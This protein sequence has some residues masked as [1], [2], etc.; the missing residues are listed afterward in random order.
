MKILYLMTEPLGIGG[1]Q[2]DMLALSK[3]FTEKGHEY[4]LAT[5]DGEIR[6]EFEANGG[7][8]HIIDFQYSGLAGLLS[9]ANKLRLLIRKL[10]VDV[11]APQSVRTSIVAWIAVRLM[12]FSYRI[13]GGNGKLPLVTTIHNIHNPVHFSYGG[14]ILRLCADYV[15]FESNYER[16]RL[17]SSGLTA[18]RSSV[19]HSGIDL[20]KLEP[21]AASTHLLEQWGINSEKDI[22]LGIVAR[23]SEEKGH[24]YLFEA[25]HIARQSRPELKLLVIGDGPL[26]DELE[27][28]VD[29]L[30][31][32]DCITFTGT[33][34][35]IPEYLSIIDVF[36]LSST[37]ESFPLAA[38]EAMAS[39]KAVVAPRI[40]GCGE[41]V[42]EGSTGLL[43]EAANVDDLAEKIVAI[44]APGMSVKFGAAGRARAEE[45]FSLKSWINGDEAIY[46]QSQKG[47]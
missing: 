46:I 14:W 39:G 44:T 20:D 36:T 34:R 9:A 43:F 41:V 32:R 13:E 29:S 22:V 19:V 33:Q 23:L 47:F 10:G 3:G 37:R 12:P 17:L 21:M 1:V 40:G 26:R 16:D 15:I 11:V 38:R 4:H 31:M 24:H 35:N 6:P 7:Q 2:S 28:K 8:L 42:D 45:H 25:L 27:A 30:A 18:G 5:K